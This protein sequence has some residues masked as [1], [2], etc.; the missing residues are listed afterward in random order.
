MPRKWITCIGIFTA[1]VVCMNWI[2]V[3]EDSLQKNI[4]YLGKSLKQL[5]IDIKNAQQDK[6]APPN[7]QFLP[8]MTISFQ[9]F[10]R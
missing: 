8:V 4:S 5:E 2:L 9:Q 10:W 1:S 6:N 7:D 3:S